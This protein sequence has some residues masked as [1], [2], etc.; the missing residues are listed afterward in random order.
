MAGRWGVCAE[1]QPARVDTSCWA[2]KLAQ[3]AQAIVWRP[4]SQRLLVIKFEFLS[5]R[6]VEKEQQLCHMMSV[7]QATF[8]YFCP[9]RVY[10]RAERRAVAELVLGGQTEGK[11]ADL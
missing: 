4:R 7:S 2:W 6:L 9:E 11:Q 5:G 3:T 1:L 8:I 10:Q